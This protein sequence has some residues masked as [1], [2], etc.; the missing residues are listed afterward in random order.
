MLT[1]GRHS[2]WS[3]HNGGMSRVVKWLLA[4]AL[5]LVLVPGAVALA[6]QQWV[7]SADFRARVAQQ[8]TARLRVPVEIGHVA[9]AVWP[10]PA[11]ALE[12]VQVKSRPVLTIARLEARPAWPALLQGRLEIATLVVREATLPEPAVTALAG[13]L[14]YPHSRRARAHL[15]AVRRRARRGHPP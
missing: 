11:V 10:V 13:A 4:G 7:G 5:V 2:C 12:R 8:A 15:R 14:A 1:G 3:R 6:L 9:V